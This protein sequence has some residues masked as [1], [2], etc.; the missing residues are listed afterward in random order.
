MLSYNKV[1]LDE[2]RKWTQIFIFTVLCGAWK[3]LEGLKGLHKTFRGTT[4]KC[5][6]KGYVIFYLKLL[7]EIHGTRGVNEIFIIELVTHVVPL[8]PFN[9]V[10]FFPLLYAF[11]FNI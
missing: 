10:Q 4:K 7:S 9:S 6:N 2:N 8:F 3:D 1:I 11:H 5:E